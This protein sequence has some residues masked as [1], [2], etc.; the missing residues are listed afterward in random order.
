M[1]ILHARSWPVI[2]SPRTARQSKIW[3]RHSAFIVGGYYSE[4]WR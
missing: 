2:S 3:Q 1:Q 4:D